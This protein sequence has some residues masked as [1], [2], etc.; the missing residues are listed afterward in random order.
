MPQ[1]LTTDFVLLKCH[2]QHQP[3]CGSGYCTF[4]SSSRG[5][6]KSDL[7]SWVTGPFSGFCSIIVSTCTAWSM[8]L[9]LS[10]AA[11]A[12]FSLTSALSPLASEVWV[13]Q[14]LVVY[15]RVT[16]GDVASRVECSMAL[17]N[18][19]RTQGDDFSCVCISPGAIRGTELKVPFF[20]YCQSCQLQRPGLAVPG[21]QLS[22]EP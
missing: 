17:I 1:A 22:P 4:C 11:T 20:D 19:G 9:T 18:T 8:A 21:S 15:Y 6:T 12:C 10:S 13:H 3:S 16:Q 2:S 7:T 5:R 14:P